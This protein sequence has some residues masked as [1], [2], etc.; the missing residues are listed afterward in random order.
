[1]TGKILA[2]SK[3]KKALLYKATR[4]SSRLDIR[5][6]RPKA[7][8]VFLFASGRVVELPLKYGNTKGRFWAELGRDKVLS[9]ALGEMSSVVLAGDMFED[10]FDAI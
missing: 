8:A 4:C 3:E 5:N 6:Q 2:F 9:R 1:L 7:A 10:P